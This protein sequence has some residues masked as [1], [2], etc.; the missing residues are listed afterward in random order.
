MKTKDG[1]QI[2]SLDGSQDPSGLELQLRV[3][4]GDTRG[5]EN[6]TCF[7]CKTDKPVTE[8]YRNS[9]SKSG[10]S[11]WCKECQKSHFQSRYSSEP[12]LRERKSKARRK[13]KDKKR[14]VI[15]EYFKSHPCVDCG[16]ADYCVLD[17]DHRDPNEKRYGIAH[18]MGNNH[19]ISTLLVEM[20]KCDVR[21][22]NC[23][24]RRTA[25][26]QGWWSLTTR[27]EDDDH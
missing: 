19:S 4:A 18:I 22:A 3:P 11:S 5:M 17:F 26:Q 12:Q 6:K 8:F 9:S 7:K 24:R 1:S 10:Y 14:T 21:C 2:P 27:R 13:N 23:H 15:K 25:Q 20:D 16:E